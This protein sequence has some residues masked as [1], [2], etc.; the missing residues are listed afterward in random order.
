MTTP[1]KINERASTTASIPNVIQD[2]SWDHHLEDVE[3]NDVKFEFNAPLD[4][5]LDITT[6]MEVDLP[7]LSSAEK[8]FKTTRRGYVR[9][10]AEVEGEMFV[11]KL[12]KEK[13]K[14]VNTTFKTLF[15]AEKA[16]MRL[17]LRDVPRADRDL[18]FEQNNIAPTVSSKASLRDEIEANFARRKRFV[19]T[20]RRSNKAN[21]EA[22]FAGTAMKPL[23]SSSF[24]P[25]EE[26]IDEKASVPE[27]PYPFSFTSAPDTFDQPSLALADGSTASALL[28][29]LKE[30]E[31]AFAEKYL[32]AV[33]DTAMPLTDFHTNGAIRGF[34]DGSK[35]FSKRRGVF[36]KPSLRPIDS[37][38]DV[39]LKR[40][41]NYLRW[42]PMSL[43]REIAKD[44]L[45]T[46]RDDFE[47]KKK[48]NYEVLVSSMARHINSAFPPSDKPRW[49]ETNELIHFDAIKL[50]K[51]LRRSSSYRAYCNH[52]LEVDKSPKDPETLLMLVL[53]QDPAC[54]SLYL[55]CEIEL[56]QKYIDRI[57]TEQMIS[58]AL[59]QSLVEE[60]VLTFGSSFLS[61]F[62]DYVERFVEGASSIL[63]WMKD[64]GFMEIFRI[65]T[66]T[67]CTVRMLYRH[68]K[69][70]KTVSEV[71]FIYL[72]SVLSAEQVTY[73]LQR[74]MTYLGS[75]F[76]GEG[77]ESEG[78]VLE[79]IL[80]ATK[81]VLSS[82]VV[83]A[84]K[85]MILSIISTKFFGKD[86]AKAIYRVVGQAKKLSLM[87]TFVEILSSVS[88][89]FRFGEQI[90]AGAPISDALFSADPVTSSMQLVVK[91]LQWK[92][93]YYTGLPVEGKKGARE[94][95]IEMKP[96]LQTLKSFIDTQP[97]HA[98]II[99]MT[100][101]FADGSEFFLVLKNAIE[102]GIRCAPF[103]AIIYGNPGVGKSVVLQLNQTINAEIRGR[104]FHPSEVYTRCK[105]S[106]YWE[107]YDPYSNPVIHYSEAGNVNKTIV[108]SKGDEIV[109]EI[110]SIVDS[111]RFNADMAFGSKGTV[112]AAPE[113]VIIDT[114]TWDLNLKEATNNFAA[115]LRRFVFTEVKVVQRFQKG[116]GVDS[117]KVFEELGEGRM[118][119]AYTFRVWRA[120]PKGNILFDEEVLMDHDH[121]AGV[122]RYI[123]LM[124]DIMKAHIYH[125]ERVRDLLLAGSLT[126]NYQKEVYIERFFK[127]GNFWSKE[128]LDDA[129]VALNSLAKLKGWNIAETQKHIKL[130][131][132]RVG[133]SW[134]D[135]RCV[136][137]E[138]LKASS[139]S[140]VAFRS[141]Y[142]HLREGREADNAK[143]S[144]WMCDNIPSE[145]MNR[146]VVRP[147][148]LL[149]APIPQGMRPN[150]PWWE[151][152]YNRQTARYGSL[153][154]PFTWWN[155]SL[156]VAWQHDT[157]P[158]FWLGMVYLSC[159]L[160]LFSVFT[161]L[162]IFL[163][164]FAF[165]I[166][167]QL[168]M[169][170]LRMR[171]AARNLVFLVGTRIVNPVTQAVG[172]VSNVVILG[173]SVYC[174]Y[175]TLQL[176]VCT[177]RGFHAWMLTEE[178]QSEMSDL[179][180]P[181]RYNAVINEI[182]KESDT[183]KALI[184]VENKLG[185]DLGWQ[186][187]IK[188]QR[189]LPFSGK[190]EDLVKSFAANVR[191]VEI[192]WGE[193]NVIKTHIMGI[194]GNIALINTH[195]FRNTANSII[196]RVF[197][198]EFANGKGTLTS[199]DWDPK[200]GTESVIE[201][202]EDVCAIWLAKENFSNII[203]HICDEISFKKTTGF[204]KENETP[205]SGPG[206]FSAPVL[207]DHGS[208][209]LKPFSVKRVLKYI[210]PEHKSG[211]CGRPIFV[212][213]GSASGFAGIHCGG[214][215]D[216]GYGATVVRK[217]AERALAH[218]KDLHTFV[219]N[220][221]AS[222][223]FQVALPH[224]KSLVHYVDLSVVDYLGR[225]PSVVVNP[226]QKS[227]VVKTKIF[228]LA[229][230]WFAEFGLSQMKEFGV[231]MMQAQGSGSSYI[232]PINIGIEKM[233]SETAPLD[234]MLLRFCE[235]V[236]FDKI[237][238]G[239]KKEG[240]HS[241]QPW[242]LEASI[243]GCPDSSVRRINMSTSI[244][245]GF[246]GNKS[247]YFPIVA[248][249]QFITREPVEIIK[250]KI[251]E[252]ME[253]FKRNETVGTKCKV[254]L[255]DEP[256]EKSK[257]VIGKTRLFYVCSIEDLILA[258]MYLGPFYSL[259][260]AYSHVF[261]CAVGINMHRN[262]GDLYVK[263]TNHSKNMMEGDFGGFDLK[264]P[265]DIKKAASNIIL[266]VLAELGYNEVAL[267]MARG[268]LSD[269][270]YPVIEVLGD[271]IKV[272]GLQP[273]GKY[274][275]A[276]D[277]CL[278]NLLMLVYAWYATLIVQGEGIYNV[279][280]LKQSS[281]D[282]FFDH[283]L[284]ATY[285]DD[286]IN[287]V[288][289]SHKD[290]FNNLVFA[291][292]VDKLF[293]MEFT[294]ASKSGTLE[295]FVAPEKM[296]FL[297]RTFVYHADH[298]R[299][300]A[301]LEFD[302]LLR[303]LMWTIPS[304]VVTEDDQM[305]GV[306]ASIARESSF[307]LSRSQ[308][309]I[310][311]L[312][313][314]RDIPKFY[315]LE[316]KDVACAMPIFEELFLRPL[317]DIYSDR[318]LSG[319]EDQETEYADSEGGERDNTL[320]F[321]VARSRV[322]SNF[323]GHDEPITREYQRFANYSFRDTIERE[324]LHYQTELKSVE[325]KIS[326]LGCP[327]GQLSPSCVRSTT[328]YANDAAYR[329]HCEE[330]LFYFSAQE[331]LTETIRLLR[332]N[333]AKAVK[334]RGA[335]SEAD[336]GG[337]DS[338]T[339]DTKET[340]ENLTTMDKESP[341]VISSD[342][343]LIKGKSASEDLEGFLMRPQELY[344]GALAL[345]TDH[346]ILLDVVNVFFRYPSLR[347]KLKNYGFIQ[348]T[349]NVRIM[350]SVSPFHQGGFLCSM[351]PFISSN[352]MAARNTGAA[353]ILAKRF[354][355]LQYM[356]AGNLSKFV[357]VRENIPLEF[358]VKWTHPQP[359]ARLF[360]SQ[361]TITTALQDFEDLY[362]YLTLN[363]NSV[364][365]LQSV[366]T[367]PSV[368]FVY[369][370]GWLSDVKL[371]GL[372]GTNV[373][374]TSEADERKTG[375]VERF[376]TAAVKVTAA[377]SKVTFLAPYAIAS[378]LVFRGL[379]TIS[380]H[381]GFS[382]PTEISRPMRIRPDAFQ[383]TALT[384]GHD[385]SQILALDQLIEMPVDGNVVSKAYDE[386]SIGSI[387]ARETLLCT[388]AISTAA[389]TMVPLL[390]IAVT[391]R[392]TALSMTTSFQLTN[393]GFAAT[394]FMSWRGRMKY[395]FKFICTQFH[396]MRVAIY[397][398][399]N[400]S[401]SVLIGSALDLNKQRMIIL[402]LAD[403]Q[404]ITV[405]VNWNS[406]RMYLLNA[407]D[408]LMKDT[409]NPSVPLN[410]VDSANGMLM[411]VPITQLQAP[412]NTSAEVNVF[413][414]SDDMEFN[415]LCD[416]HMPITLA[417]SE[418]D[419]GKTT[420]VESTCVDLC[421]DTLDK[422]DVAK[423]HFGEK[424]LSFRA[425]IKRFSTTNSS[426]PSGLGAA[427]VNHLYQIYP[428]L[429]DLTPNVFGS[430][431][432]RASLLGF[433]RGAYLGYKGGVRK[434]IRVF[435]QTTA[436][437]GPGV[438]TTVTLLPPGAAHVAFTSGHTA[439]TAPTTQTGTLL[440]MPA[441]NAG[442]EARLPFYSNNLFG[443]AGRRADEFGR[444]AGLGVMQ[445]WSFRDYQISV[446]CIGAVATQVCFAED[447]AAADD[448][449]LI[450]Y[451]G[452]P[453]YSR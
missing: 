242:D 60:N 307:H 365:Q 214:F 8:K 356:S 293:G 18:Y 345:G 231:P 223:S 38:L 169:A 22:D 432:S 414:S 84:I 338:G 213:I 141:I 369:V 330:Y 34:Y 424:P 322:S 210:M 313:M 49:Y 36:P 453:G 319:E 31:N 368:P 406:Q 33:E 100:K 430:T 325:E 32:S 126:K 366:A 249:D 23:L 287:A 132:S 240:I 284:P 278:V 383:S 262:A 174:I 418:A 122:F 379:E 297:K 14:Y 130:L 335:N 222:L 227:R 253:M 221:E 398:E 426:N 411:V 81:M 247:G 353:H 135:E 268:V 302:S 281:L 133:E 176:L 434:K 10:L 146:A 255:K 48:V 30:D 167:F 74:S 321:V 285:G 199:L 315:V 323:S 170:V 385:T 288:S 294:P 271:I 92:S 162:P 137:I 63:E 83:A 403:T 53:S 324:I 128:G 43:Y 448:F 326:E 401:Q 99:E 131:V 243:N 245:P 155:D 233:T 159:F 384:I 328:E 72:S 274:A 207:F 98:R 290:V 218:F 339:V 64:K 354:A 145:M 304:G 393:L 252:K 350:F 105:T 68:R 7:E 299:I 391:P 89:L 12:K 336:I 396:R 85:N 212:K 189:P 332:R 333:L 121:P 449:S 15:K 77:P 17:K 362:D 177:C 265:F 119:E 96:A 413:V 295:K 123:E 79:G 292:C 375:P 26:D 73:M 108:Q 269:S 277:N 226:K 168:C 186:N 191:R 360:N 52:A 306:V 113:L 125:T 166:Y 236:I 404:E 160:L 442:V 217:E 115:G 344:A 234:H 28:D 86:F 129:S 181:S 257:C 112:F 348:F 117:A 163:V 405:C 444:I 187:V 256:R 120:I 161:F 101:T 248:E 264:M 116:S 237:I 272:P 420:A 314:I 317:S 1:P 175:K 402:D 387:C 61:K 152:W 441:T 318:I 204:I 259:M 437:L 394:P 239:L 69:C 267:Q 305:L 395:R 311:R 208:T 154:Y 238:T 59:S 66:I 443:W 209:T 342:W 435:G 21:S 82:P 24:I 310:L 156:P 67:I 75:L 71:L 341:D 450:Y 180:I 273:S 11:D 445:P 270:L 367:A 361:T 312:K 301:P 62:R 142:W 50:N 382:M 447:T 282:D 389:A 219:P 372:T 241:L 276:E 436:V 42:R 289:D 165:F 46:Q 298:E 373:A 370:Y 153:L 433:M 184:K 183:G 37:R 416:T 349:M 232:N 80:S 45:D 70:K 76:S 19:K 193:N 343:T 408:A 151:R 158:L 27:E 440:F 397:F 215:K 20:K 254:A 308:Y 429:P 358:S 431:S 188:V 56:V 392:S 412:L 327:F 90:A 244:G 451:M 376:S 261:Y 407:T 138:N 78:T 2:N 386:M 202:A 95:I 206:W 172:I 54:K 380:A 279:R 179:T 185:K 39:R 118:A 246:T 374:I 178:A 286:L 275:T 235:N 452:P 364:N 9:T 300:V 196:I 93:M 363:I 57:Y 127:E 150:M 390:R 439:L 331:S 346:N 250:A 110:T 419:M 337:M 225:D 359:M 139:P 58:S 149:N 355:A 35:S 65:C 329:S 421:E 381:F 147:P 192:M 164:Y 438:G 400:I 205:L 124:K 91:N 446:D 377:L 134:D 229:P 197:K 148:A 6:Y 103:G 423:L 296:S 388:A 203:P 102:S 425:L 51:L 260:V 190:M 171:T 216:Y 428:I 263:L 55:D 40:L 427:G 399:P 409:I 16:K 224:P 194:Y 3:D 111:L 266:R 422:G 378:N 157:C 303:S 230:T 41:S 200:Q 87:D 143:V 5:D 47:S 106:Q 352:D 107:G 258:R 211:D 195:V 198:S 415:G 97:R 371:A 280:S 334:I 351:Y 104:K 114:N 88:E 94:L 25:R 291:E 44:K 251:V 357:D 140:T 347:A 182:E 417:Y 320:F 201:I 228:D 220:S 410:H 13:S 309:E 4:S 136:N 29:E 109:A 173:T 316:E 144:S 283:N 340:E